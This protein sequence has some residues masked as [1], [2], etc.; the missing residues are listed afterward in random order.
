MIPPTFEGLFYGV[1]G[2]EGTHRRSVEEKVCGWVV[3]VEK[4]TD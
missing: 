2:D 1:G 3:Q 4:I